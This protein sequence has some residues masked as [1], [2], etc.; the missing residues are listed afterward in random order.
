M[1]HTMHYI[2]KYTPI[3]L[4]SAMG[5]DCVYAN[6][7]PD[8]FGVS[9]TMIGS[10]ICGFGKSLV[11][12]AESGD[13]HE[14]VLTNC[15]DTIRSVSDVLRTEGKLPYVHMIDIPHVDTNCTRDQL[16][17]QL[18][19]LI[20]SYEQYSGNHFNREKFIGAL[21]ISRAQCVQPNQPYIA[22]LGGRAGIE[23]HKLCLQEMPLM[24]Q[25]LTCV[26]G[27]KIGAGLPSDDVLETMDTD[28]LLSWYAGELLGQLPCMRMLDRTGRKQLYNDPNLKGIIY[29]T[30]R[31]CDFYSFE[32][33][34]IKSH[35]SVPIVKI[36]SDY[37]TGAS[38]QLL[39]RLQAFAEEIEMTYKDTPEIFRKMFQGRLG[40]GTA[41]SGNGFPA[42]AD[43][44]NPTVSG[45]S[46]ET[47][48]YGNA[49]GTPDRNHSVSAYFAGIDSGSAS[50]DVV[51]L[52]QDANIV[53]GIV[54]PTGAG[55]SMSAEKAL[56]AAVEDAK[57]T[58]A[59]IS[60]VVTTG[61]GRTAIENSDKSITEI[62]CHARGAHFLDPSVRT[63]I[64]IGGQDSKVIVMDQDG[65]VLNFVM[66]DKCAAGTGRF[67]DMMA[68]TMEMTLDEMSLKGLTYKEDINISST[69]TVFAES[70][71]VSLIA[72]N[73]AT[74]D[75]V[76]GLDKSVA[77]RTVS[78]AARVGG[79]APFMMTGGVSRNK[80]L[81][82][83]LEEKLGAR[84]V[85]SEKAQLCGALG[86]AL[87]AR[88]MGN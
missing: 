44:E 85:I 15:C 62:T 82:K 81:V 9:E 47:A 33:S 86:A 78:L 50:T 77:S 18:K 1:S 61:Y 74:D 60:R 43:S 11:D 12:L 46:V 64:D 71:V 83:A 25:N 87:Y 49:N 14:L 17:E 54:L 59:D 52:D 39:T 28:A 69:C 13:V 7:M 10:N 3:E 57:L 37:T 75:I 48:D 42:T 26:A 41:D 30:I 51:I 68:R 29:H 24:V 70:E 79:T 20:A 65:R 4:L 31:F 5:A 8:G 22:I 40:K 63:V 73:K 55:A 66:N 72:E 88:E 32:Y 58:R 84:L 35:V 80:G 19:S 34:E 23:L 76:H 2:C 53:S 16:T 6:H 21:K 27:R 56:N 67:L 36:E 38:G 45:T